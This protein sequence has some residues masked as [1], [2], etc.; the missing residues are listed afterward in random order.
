[1][2]IPWQRLAWS[3]DMLDRGEI[4][5]P[6]RWRSSLTVYAYA[7]PLEETVEDYPDD[8]IVYLKLS[9]SIT[10]WTAREEIPLRGYLPQAP[11]EWQGAAW[12]AIN[13]LDWIDEYQ[14]CLTAIAQIAIVPRPQDGAADEDYPYFIDFEPKKRELYEAITDTR[15]MLSGSSNKVATQKGATTT[16]ATES[17]WNAGLGLSIPLPGG[18]TLGVGGGGGGTS[19]NTTENVDITTT[20]ASIERRETQGRSTQLSQMYQLFNGYHPGTNRAVF[21]VFAR[22]HAATEALQ[23]NNNLINGERRLEGV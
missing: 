19:R 14:P 22:P 5:R 21:V 13:V 23:L 16:N 15:E 10:G 8:R 6:P 17:N 2:D 7:V 9:A 18:A 11:D 3:R 20:E 1:I 12:D 4:A